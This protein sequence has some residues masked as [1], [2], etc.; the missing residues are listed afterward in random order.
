MPRIGGSEEVLK[1]KELEA[2]MFHEEKAAAY[3]NATTQSDFIR[4]SL[5][6]RKERWQQFRNCISVRAN[7]SFHDLLSERQFRGRINIDHTTKQ[8]DIQA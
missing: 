8:L 5:D 7:N 4:R 3:S 2:K 6:M 1:R